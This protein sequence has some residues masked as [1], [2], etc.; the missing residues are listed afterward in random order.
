MCCCTQ[1]LGSWCSV[2]RRIAKAFT[3]TVLPKALPSTTLFFAALVDLVV[4]R[5]TGLAAVAT[6]GAR[7]AKRTNRL[8]TLPE[9]RFERG[10]KTVMG[11]ECSQARGRV[12]VVS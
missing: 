6:D 7:Q 11:F 2:L 10:L 9:K 12:P 1:A 5:A 8:S 3:A 4:F